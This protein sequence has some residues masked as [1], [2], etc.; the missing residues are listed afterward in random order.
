MSGWSFL[1]AAKKAAGPGEDAARLARENMEV[2]SDLLKQDRDLRYLQGQFQSANPDI[3]ATKA[4]SSAFND[5]MNARNS[6]AIFEEAGMLSPQAEAIPTLPR[7]RF[8]ANSSPA[9]MSA[10]N[11]PSARNSMSVFQEN[12]MLDTGIVPFQERGLVP[13]TEKGLV[14]V[15]I[16]MGRTSAPRV[17]A[18]VDDAPQ[19]MRDVTPPGAS[20]GGRGGDIPP[21]AGISGSFDDIPMDVKQSFLA[22]N[23]G[24]IGAAALGG[25]GL[26]GISALMDD[27]QQ[28]QQAAP[29][30]APSNAQKSAVPVETPASSAKASVGIKGPVA[31]GGSGLPGSAPQQDPLKVLDFGQGYKDTAAALQAEQERRNDSVLRSQLGKAASLLGASIA[32][33]KPVANELFDAN[34]KEAD[35]RLQQHNDRMAKEKLDPN[36]PLSKG[37]RE[38]A[39]NLLGIEIRGD[40][41]AE[42][43][44]KTM[45]MLQ[46]YYQSG[47][48]RQARK[49]ADAQR[50]KDRAAALEVA[51]LQRETASETKRS[52]KLESYTKEMRKDLVSGPLA[53]QYESVVNAKTALSDLDA[54]RKN[55]TGYSD[56]GTLMRALK[57]LQG[58]A[59]VVRET[60]M[61]MGKAAGS[62]PQTL[63][64]Y[65][66]Q[67]AD[68]R[69]LQPKQR[70][71]ILDT[72]NQMDNS[73]TSLY[74]RAAEP[75]LENA[76]EL[77]LNTNY[78]LPGILRDSDKKEA[79]TQ[80]TSSYPKQV[81]NM[82]TGAMATVSNAQEE[83]EANSE[84]FR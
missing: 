32:G 72:I 44:M 54:F 6:A 71:E 76:R 1:K 33:T 15:D 47:E 82:Q 39:K 20:G 38:M 14:P 77:G 11:Q 50:S 5:P 4:V 68:G 84:G 19:P 22:R 42:E 31:M 59:S 66:Q 79:S 2:A 81:R 78:I 62:L 70:Q 25:A 65:I 74:L 29:A 34:M 9:E 12:N 8:D 49:E 46:G 21:V 17:G 27:G 83:A 58:D 45:P 63:Q 26:L 18:L 48:N 60:E 56:Y 16:N 28:A 35:V 51:K 7:G 23:K 41:S 55:P 52:E 73:A 30:V 64:N 69:S 13:L 80:K 57:V 40:A 53:K 24:K 10:F 43:L 61:K 75:Y 67:M 3:D 37:M 36:S